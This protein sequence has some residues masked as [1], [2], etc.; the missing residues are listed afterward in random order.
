MSRTVLYAND[1]GN[2]LHIAAQYADQRFLV[3]LLT[4]DIYDINLRDKKDRNP[5]FYS[6]I[7]DDLDSVKA[8]GSDSFLNFTDSS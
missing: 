6:V 8:L 5:I 4:L 7:R 3:K 1:Y 2:I